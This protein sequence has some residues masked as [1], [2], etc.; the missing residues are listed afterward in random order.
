M[1]DSTLPTQGY[2]RQ[3]RLQVSGVYRDSLDA[4]VARQLGISEDRAKRLRL[5]E[6]REAITAILSH[7]HSDPVKA[8]NFRRLV[9]ESL[10][11]DIPINSSPALE[12]AAQEKDLAEDLAEKVHEQQG[13]PESRRALIRA[14][15][16]EIGLQEQRLRALQAEEELA[17]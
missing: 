9:A 8:E 16:G 3:S 4:K 11:N 1:T 6:I 15:E 17:S 12:L 5:T 13:T 14:I 10:S 2:R 7:S